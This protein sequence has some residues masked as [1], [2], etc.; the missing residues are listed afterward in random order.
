MVCKDDDGCHLLAL[1]DTRCDGRK[2]WRC[3]GCELAVGLYSSRMAL[4]TL[5][6]AAGTFVEGIG[7]LA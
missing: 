4:L 7:G 2:M 1:L 6:T 3:A 5:A